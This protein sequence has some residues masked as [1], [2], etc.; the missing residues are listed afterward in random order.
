MDKN[1]TYLCGCESQTVDYHISGHPPLTQ[2]LPVYD[3]DGNRLCPVHNSLAP[4]GSSPKILRGDYYEACNY[5]PTLC[6]SA[7]YASDELAGISLI[8]GGL[9][10]CS[11]RHCGVAKMSVEEAI[12][13]RENW[14]EFAREYALPL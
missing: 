7:S 5:H 14:A 3:N 12:E 13:R 6:I 8:N 11:P 1:F 4:E 10:S 2:F 9:S